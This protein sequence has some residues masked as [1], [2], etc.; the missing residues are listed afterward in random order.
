MLLRQQLGPRY[1]SSLQLVP[2]PHPGL[3]RPWPVARYRTIFS[4][5]YSSRLIAQLIRKHAVNCR[6]HVVGHSLGAHIAINLAGSYPELV[7]TVFVS[8]FEI[9]P[10]TTFSSFAPYAI[11][12]DQRVQRLVPNSLISYLIDGTDIQGAEMTSS[13]LDLC[14]QI[15]PAMVKQHGH[16]LGL[17]GL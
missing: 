6:A 8:G 9:Y 11:W 17:Q 3:A 1:A 7:N 13:T 2:C 15:A 12:F 16:Q 4:V 5:E 14:R 10:P